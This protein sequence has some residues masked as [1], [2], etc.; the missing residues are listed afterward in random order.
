MA[1]SFHPHPAVVVAK[2]ILITAALDV[3]LYLT[4]DILD[5]IYITL[6]LAVTLLGVL[7]IILAV[8][9]TRFL[10][11][12][13]DENTITYSAGVFATREV[14][15]PFRKI[16]EASFRQSLVQRVFGVGTLDVDTAGGDM[17]AIS[18][19]NIRYSD[20]KKILATINRNTGSEDGT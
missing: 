16:T 4:R 15:L 13:I 3:L 17:M 12:T 2:L 1:M 20:L 8:I 14:V 18:V 7:L 9:R 19:G 6:M 11:I 10:K 5:R